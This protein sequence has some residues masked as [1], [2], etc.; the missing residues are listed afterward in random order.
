MPTITVDGTQLEIPTKELEQ[1]KEKYSSKSIKLWYVWRSSSTGQIVAIG[2]YDDVSIGEKFLH[3]FTGRRITSL[4][5]M[6]ATKG[7]IVSA[8]TK[9]EALSIGGHRA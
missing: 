9:Q 2:P 7:C 3:T 4:V 6:K 1:L 5:S 8:R